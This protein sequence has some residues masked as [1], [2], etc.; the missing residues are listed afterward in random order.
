M[1]LLLVVMIGLGSVSGTWAGM[2]AGMAGMVGAA[3]A[4]LPADVLAWLALMPELATAQQGM[5][6]VESQRRLTN[7]SG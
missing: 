3:R 1:R 4:D 2:A 5:A 6:V 7:V